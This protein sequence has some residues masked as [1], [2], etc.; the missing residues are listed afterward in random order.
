MLKVL[1][2]LTFKLKIFFNVNVL[3]KYHFLMVNKL[4]II[5]IIKQ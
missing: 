5:I 1:I 3:N 4:N 2:L